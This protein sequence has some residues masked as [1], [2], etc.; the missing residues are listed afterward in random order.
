MAIRGA[1]SS[2]N[3]N[4]EALYVRWLSELNKNSGQIAGGKGANLAE[5]HNSKFPVP[6]AFIITTKAYYH[7]IEES[8]I[9]NKINDILDSIDVDN[10]EELEEKSKEIRETI[11]KAELPEDLKSE[12]LEAY[13]NISTDKAT[14][15][16]AGKYALHILKHTSEPI[17]VAVRSSAT[18]EDLDDSSFAGQQETYL[19]IKGNHQLL[20][21][22]KKVFASLFTARAIYYR[23]KR[24]F[25]NEKFALAVVVQKMIDSDKSGVI[26]S[27]NPV[28]NNNNVMIEAVFGLGEGIVSGRIKP[29]NYEVSR[30]LKLVSKV[31]SEKKIAITRNSQG[32]TEEIVLNSSKAKT[33]V[34]EEYEIKRLADYAIKIEE[35]YN[36]PQDIE[37]A[38]E[39]GEIYIVQSRPVTTHV[40]ESKE[41]IKG[42]FIL[43]GLAASPGVASGKVKIIKD[44]S[45]LE[46][47]QKGDILVTQMTNPDM[48]VTMQR[49]AAI[50]T[51]EG[52]ITSHAAIVSREM[53]IPA[54]VGT[55]HATKLLKEGMIVTVDGFNGVI[56][57]GKREERKAEIKPIVAKTKTKIKVILDLPDYAER[58]AQTGIDSVGLLRLE[59]I[60]AESGKHPVAFLKENKLNEYEK[61]IHDGIEK[62]SKHFNEVWIRTSDIR[63]DEFSNLEGSPKKPELNPM[64]GMHGIRFSLKNPEIF[65][66][67]LLAIKTCAEKHKNKI[68]GIMFPQIISTEEVIEAKKHAESLELLKLSNIKI[69]IMVETPAACLIIKHLLKT[70]IDFISFGTN[71]L[72]QYT[73]AIDRGN[74]QVQYLYNETHPA[75]LNAIKRVLRTCQEFNVESSICGQAA[76]RKEM[77]KFLIENGINSISVNADAAH[78]ISVFVS[79]I[80]KQTLNQNKPPHQPQ[81]H[82]SHKKLQPEQLVQQVKNKIEEEFEEISEEDQVS[83]SDNQERE[84]TPILAKP[85]EK[86]ENKNNSKNQNKDDKNIKPDQPPAYIAGILDLLE[87]P[88]S[89][90]SEME[91]ILALKA[92]FGEN[93]ENKENTNKM[94]NK[95]EAKQREAKQD[96]EVEESK[97]NEEVLDIF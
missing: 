9:K 50:I 27:I 6:P 75:V 2:S 51:D 79:E 78:E 55:G 56:Y 91:E 67:E 90:H 10:T 12:I 38:I 94:S 44:I 70:K 46:K 30:D 65:K 82:N 66:A 32:D 21:A 69:G 5:M 81:Q 31:I 8:G 48:V 19:N 47:V 92:L 23:K 77:V 84:L 39:S 52:G 43:S 28:K 26:F 45:Q 41:E 95:K 76:S 16:A 96:E 34:L 61:I 36:K 72:T 37:F 53:G 29:D 33:Q 86:Q 58:A 40:K 35:H 11:I 42:N 73:L 49:S 7:L 97:S 83:D 62:I 63:S 71:D 57:E 1:K 4:L 89:R 88:K 25:S 54:V 59:G 17:F 68:F 74:E 80:E 93:Q 22:V 85:H 14:L 60:I 3:L 13:E 24:G 64:L 87:I 20:E 15:E 18:T